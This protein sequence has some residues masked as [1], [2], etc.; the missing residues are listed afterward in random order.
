[1]DSY[2]VVIERH[3]TVFTVRVSYS[4]PK[5]SLEYTTYIKSN[6]HPCKFR[7]DFEISIEEALPENKWNA[8][9]DEII[10][11]AI[12]SQELIDKAIDF[13][14]VD[15]IDIAFITLGSSITKGPEG[16]FKPIITEESLA[17]YDEKQQAYVKNKI[18]E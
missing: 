15:L 7:S 12:N 10:D 14:M 9:Y 6:F 4:R 5:D 18:A 16:V 11:L 2:P 8:E 13:A 17:E 3:E 1:M